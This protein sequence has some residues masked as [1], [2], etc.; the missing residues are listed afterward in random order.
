MNPIQIK[1]VE[2]KNLLIKWQDGKEHTIPLLKLRKLCPCA[3][4][5]AEREKQ[6]KNY[7]P[8]FSENQITVSEIRQVGKY[9]ISIFWN[10]GHN[11]GIYEYTFLRLIG[12]NSKD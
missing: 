10:D 12:E 5:L 4:C 6:G 3:T 1:L 9:A 11:T 7:I 8:V 2:G